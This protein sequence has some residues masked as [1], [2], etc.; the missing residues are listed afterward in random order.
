MKTIFAAL[1]L[2]PMVAFMQSGCMCALTVKEAGTHYRYL[3]IEGLWTNSIGNVMVEC[4]LYDRRRMPRK[5][6]SPAIPPCWIHGTRRTA[7]FPR[8]TSVTSVVIPQIPYLKVSLLCLIVFDCIKLIYFYKTR[9]PNGFSNLGKRL[10][11]IH[12]TR[13]CPV[14]RRPREG[15][16]P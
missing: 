11:V 15:G 1:V 16:D 6:A 2:I 10:V 12:M 3:D 5:T 7:S 4:T 8:I 13:S 14:F 9:A